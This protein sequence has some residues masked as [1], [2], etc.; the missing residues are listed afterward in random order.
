MKR[1]LWIVASR[2]IERIADVIEVL[3]VGERIAGAGDTVAVGRN[4]ARVPDVPLVLDV[5]VLEPLAHKSR[6]RRIAGEAVE[7]PFARVAGR[8]R[9]VEDAVAEPGAV[10]HALRM[11]DA[12]RVDRV[13]RRDQFAHIGEMSVSRLPSPSSG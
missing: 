13:L 1:R 8:Q 2:M 10:D 3:Q 5:D 9:A 4:R 6:Q 7:P 11:P 12:E